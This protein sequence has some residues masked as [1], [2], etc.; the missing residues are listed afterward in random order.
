MND[1]S[2]VGAAGSGAALAA[3]P[4]AVAPKISF[5][6]AVTALRD[7]A[8][9]LAPYAYVVYSVQLAVHQSDAK[10]TQGLIQGLFGAALLAIK[11]G[12]SKG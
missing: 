3:Q 1:E 9:T 10:F 5:A 6:D 11:P 8:V 4:V 7:F 12:G 2:P